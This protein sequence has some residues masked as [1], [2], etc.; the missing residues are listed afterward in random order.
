MPIMDTS[1]P[2]ESVYARR[3]RERREN[4]VAGRARSAYKLQE[5][6]EESFSVASASPHSSGFTHQRVSICQRGCPQI[7]RGLKEAFDAAGLHP[8]K[9][10]QK[11][12]ASYPIPKKQKAA[13]RNITG[14]SSHCR[15]SMPFCQLMIVLI[16][17]HTQL[18]ISGFGRM[19]WM[20]TAT[21]SSATPAS[22][23]S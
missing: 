18:K 6:L 4:F 1:S 12:V 8:A 22:S 23:P 13:H 17:L 20:H 3:K 5:S 14:K 2:S 16:F 9:A 21:F 15:I 10:L 19:C 11:R 7:F